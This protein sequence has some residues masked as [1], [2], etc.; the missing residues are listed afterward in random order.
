[1][2]IYATINVNGEMKQDSV[3]VIGVSGLTKY[4]DGLLA[5]D[6]IDVKLPA[7]RMLAKKFA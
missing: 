1:M 7:P 2:K 6:G 5:V 4:Y 3:I